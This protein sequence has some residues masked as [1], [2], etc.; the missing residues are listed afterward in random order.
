MATGGNCRCARS[1]CR[2]PWCSTRPAGHERFRS[3]R[4]RQPRPWPSR[5]CRADLCRA[6]QPSRPAAHAPPDLQDQDRHPR[7]GRHGV[8]VLQPLTHQGIPQRRPR[9]ARRDRRQLPQRPGLPAAPAQPS[10][11]CR[12]SPRGQRAYAVCPTL[13][14]RAVSS[15]PPPSSG[16]HSPTCGRANEPERCASGTH[17]PWLWPAP[18]Q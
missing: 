10:R 5:R 16:S 18:W 13:P 3:R 9:T 4:G 1:R 15:R 7:R 12:Q 2:A 17:A 14:V 11:A 6:A 8:R